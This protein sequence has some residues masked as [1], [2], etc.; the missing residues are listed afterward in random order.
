M[1]TMSEK[2]KMFKTADNILNRVLKARYF[3]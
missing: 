3:L 1:G 2:E